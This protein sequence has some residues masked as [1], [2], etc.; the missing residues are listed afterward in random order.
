VQILL[1]IVFHLS[2]VKKIP[3][4]FDKSRL[5]QSE[6]SRLFLKNQ[7]QTKNFVISEQ[8]IYQEPGLLNR[9]SDWLWAGRSGG[10]SSS[11]GSVKNFLFFTE[12]RLSLVPTKPPT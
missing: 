5:F 9:Y 4:L 7:S 2:C 6:L 1:F 8:S 10:R 12:S 3:V 11:T